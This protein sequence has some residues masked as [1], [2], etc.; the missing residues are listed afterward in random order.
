MMAEGRLHLSS[1]TIAG[2]RYLRLVVTTPD[3]G[4]ETIEVLLDALRT[5]TGARPSATVH[6]AAGC[7]RVSDTRACSSR[8]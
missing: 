8:A 7:E 3:T 5:A 4:E 2:E 1:T 6:N